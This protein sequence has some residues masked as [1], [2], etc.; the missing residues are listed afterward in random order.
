MLENISGV[1]FLNYTTVVVLNAY[2]SSGVKLVNSYNSCDVKLVQKLSCKL[3]E[4]LCGVQL[5][6]QLS[7]KT[8]EQLCGV[9]PCIQLL[10]QL[11]CKTFEQLCGVQLLLYNSCRV[12]L[13]NSYVVL[14]CLNSYVVLHFLN[15]TV[16]LKLVQKCT[17][18][19]VRSSYNS[20]GVN[21][22]EQ[23]RLTTFLT[24][25]QCAWWLTFLTVGA[26]SS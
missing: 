18:V 9:Q 4:Q 1:K 2:K 14:N 24:V 8:S 5:L 3:F 13:L 10:Q 17:A 16:V 19:V 6:Q 15:S 25:V 12:K 23:F 26:E 21:F 7:C 22:F 20:Y 11:S